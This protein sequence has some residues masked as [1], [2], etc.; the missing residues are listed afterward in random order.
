MTSDLNADERIT[1]IKIRIVNGNPFFAYLSLYLTFEED[2]TGKRVGKDA[3]MSVNARG[4]VY[5]RK[6]FIDGITDDELLGVMCHEIFHLAFLHLTRAGRRNHLRWNISTDLC[7]NTMLL[8][9]SYSLPK[10]IRANSRNE[11]VILG[12]VIKAVDT[13]TAEE[14]YDEIP[15]IPDDKPPMIYVTFDKHDIGDG[16]KIEGEVELTE[17]EM[18]KLETEWFNRVQ[19]ASVLAQQRGQLPAGLERY[20]DK[21]KEAEIN[22]RVKLLRFVQF[23]IPH[24]QTWKSRSKV[25]HA[26]GIYLPSL[27]K[28]RIDIVI[29]VDTSGSIGEE[30]ITKFLSEMVAIARSYK[31]RVSMRVLFHDVEIQGDYEIKNG[32]I[33]KIMSMKIRGGGATSHKL[34]FE[35]VRKDIRNC[36]CLISFTDGYSDI[37]NI[38]LTDY[39]FKKMFVI[40]KEGTIPKIKR[41]LAE[42][43]KLRED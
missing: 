14:I 37:E 34:L 18:Q 32:N 39:K 20:I 1:K 33:D 38:K 24:D 23:V 9:N 11:F 35:K 27:L 21:L 31:D 15:D 36:K 41:N 22:W 16:E 7:I 19:T 3:G 4:Q 40:N 13:K 5:Y 42:I 6:E 43:I 29:G 17:A 8:A 10:G 26:L 12:K 30:E 25:G 28:E 2:T